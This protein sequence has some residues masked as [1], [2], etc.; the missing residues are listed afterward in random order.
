MDLYNGLVIRLP[1]PTM[2]SRWSR[3]NIILLACFG[4]VVLAT[5]G[6]ALTPMKPTNASTVKFFLEASTDGPGRTQEI[7][8]HSTSPLVVIAQE[9]PFLSELD[10]A[11]AELEEFVDAFAIVIEFTPH[12]KLWLESVS[13]A[14]IGKRIVVFGEFGVTRWIAAPRITARLGAGILRFAPLDLTHPEAERFV[15][16]LNETAAY[17]DKGRSR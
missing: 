16:G 11:H 4:A 15:Q 10:V 5:S 13:T 12:G 14:N 8:I 1:C 6:C 9:A 17:L 7:T 3:F 2:I